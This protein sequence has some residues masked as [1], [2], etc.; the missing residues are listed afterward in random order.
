MNNEFENALN[1]AKKYCSLKEI[2]E[3]DILK[4]LIDWNVPINQ[5]NSILQQ[6]IDENFVNNQRFANSFAHDKL[7]FNNWGKIRIKYELQLK[8]IHSEIIFNALDNID[9]ELYIQ[10]ANRLII[11]KIKTFKSSDDKQTKQKRL[12]AYMYS[13]GFEYEVVKDFLK[14]NNL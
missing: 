3:Q 7:K 11:S 12:L 9:K 8:K 1:K 4:K 14:N 5:H 2:C 10:T 13:K 6:L